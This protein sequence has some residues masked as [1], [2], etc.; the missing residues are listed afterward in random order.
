M[1]L[2]IVIKNK[3]TKKKIKKTYVIFFQ[4]KFD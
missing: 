1:G 4:N 3:T 2:A